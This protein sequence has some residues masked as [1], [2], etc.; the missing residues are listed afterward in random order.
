MLTMLF[1]ISTVLS[2]FPALSMILSRV[3]AFLLPSSARDWIFIRLTVVMAVSADEKNAERKMS[4]KSTTIC[5]PSLES[6]CVHSF[7][8]VHLF[9]FLT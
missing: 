5:I 2:I 8:D 4:I 3:C 1:P 6:N 7:L 9:R